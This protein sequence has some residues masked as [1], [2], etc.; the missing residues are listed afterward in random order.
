MGSAFFGMAPAPDVRDPEDEPV[1]HGDSPML[2]IVPLPASDGKVALRLDGELAG[3]WVQVLV[4]ECE[5]RV[6]GEGDLVLDLANLAYADQAGRG[7][8]RRL[9]SRGVTLASC[10][11]MIAA[12]LEAEDD[13]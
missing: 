13:S 6:D 12:L 1:T 9:A 7:V 5:R 3:Q 4:E 10:P 2:R 11:P 8:L